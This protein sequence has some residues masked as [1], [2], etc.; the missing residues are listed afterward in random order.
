MS[1]NEKERHAMFNW[2][3]T[4]NRK[5]PLPCPRC[6]CDYV[7]LWIKWIFPKKYAVGCEECNYMS[8]WHLTKKA[9]I[10]DWNKMVTHSDRT[11]SSCIPHMLKIG[12]N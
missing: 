10:K 12:E 7:M 11:R 6:D 3:K 9:A 2:V 1:K 5:H 8:D 4:A